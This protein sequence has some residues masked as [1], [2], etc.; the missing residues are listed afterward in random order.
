[1]A[2]RDSSTPCRRVRNLF[3]RIGDEPELD[4]IPPQAKAQPP[5]VEVPPEPQPTQ[6]NQTDNLQV[7]AEEEYHSCPFDEEVASESK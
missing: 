1:M 2:R 3:S 5:P 6:P 7:D 4:E